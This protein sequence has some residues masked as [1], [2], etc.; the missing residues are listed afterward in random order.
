MN[1][2]K[3]FIAGMVISAATLGGCSTQKP[4]EENF[5]QKIETDNSEK[6]NNIQ[7]HTSLG[8]ADT[9]NQATNEVTRF[10]KKMDAKLNEIMQN[11]SITLLEE[12]V[13]NNEENSENNNSQLEE[14]EVKPN[15]D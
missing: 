2:S 14:L 8:V 3:N 4:N 7:S 1:I 9:L 6:I 12:K 13:E 5:S 15:P 10:S 11:D